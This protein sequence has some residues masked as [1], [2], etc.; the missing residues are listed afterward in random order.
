MAQS[1]ATSKNATADSG[2][3]IGERARVRGR[4]VGDGD[5]VVQG[6][7]DGDISL[8]G[9]LTVAEGGRIKGPR[10]EATSV[11]ISGAIEGDITARGA[12]RIAAS[13]EVRG[14]LSAAEITMDEGA[15]F[16]G[17]LECEFELPEALNESAG[18]PRT[19]ARR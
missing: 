3:V 16:A 14:T 4:I 10:I 9:E 8:G 7:V 2:A 18:K 17:R 19:A 13:S 5:L 6:A 1:R 15:Q 12:I 11:A